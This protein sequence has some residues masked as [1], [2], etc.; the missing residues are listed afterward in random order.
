MGAGGN[1]GADA[2]A[3]SD[4]DGTTLLM[5]ANYLAMAPNLYPR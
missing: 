3:K 2:V 1:I 5:A 4:P